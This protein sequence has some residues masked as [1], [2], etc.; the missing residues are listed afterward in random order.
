MRQILTVCIGN[1]CRSPI[2]EELL[3]QQ[4]GPQFVVGSAGLGALVGEGADP[5]AVKLTSEAGFDI[6]HHRARQLTQEM[7]AQADL[8]LVMTSRQKKEIES[9]FS[10]ARG[11]V[12]LLMH[13]SLPAID[14]KDPYKQDKIFFSEIYKL[15][16]AGVSSWVKKIHGFKP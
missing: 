13:W 2:A 5:L 15:I 4:L 8:I 1:I 10:F 16:D 3:R 9:I 12:F 6:T 11:K 14:V 7:V